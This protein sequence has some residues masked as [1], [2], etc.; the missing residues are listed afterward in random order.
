MKNIEKI[1]D[2][3]QKRIDYFHDE[4][5]VKN[6]YEGSKTYFNGILIETTEAADENYKNNHIFLEDELGDIFWNFACLLAS[7]E[8]E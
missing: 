3:T 2:L 7:L 1:L 5:N 4:E 6:W 8:R